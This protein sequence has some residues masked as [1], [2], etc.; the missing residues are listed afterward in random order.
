MP[1]VLFV[2]TANQFRS[3]V[4][5]ACLREEL[6]LAGLGE[7]WTVESA[8]T[9]P[10]GNLVSPE[11]VR[12]LRPLGLDL[13]K[14]TPRPV[15]DELLHRSDLILVMDSSQKEALEVEF[16]GTRGRV[17][18]LGEIVDGVPYGIP[19]PVRVGPRVYAAAAHEIRELV[20]RGMPAIRAKAEGIRRSAD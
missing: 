8:G 12:A 6:E 16:P 15:T 10:P 3:P 7:G 4:A 13:E 5:A 9:W 2:C 20:R 14:H 19:D 1:S 17:F 18:L 11:I